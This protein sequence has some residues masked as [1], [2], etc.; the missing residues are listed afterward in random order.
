MEHGIKGEGRTMVVLERLSDEL[1]WSG[2]CPEFFPWEGRAREVNQRGEPL[3]DKM[4]IGYGT[5]ANL[6]FGSEERRK[7]GSIVRK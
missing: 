3:R 6:L 2:G 5:D 1:C 4:S 7:S